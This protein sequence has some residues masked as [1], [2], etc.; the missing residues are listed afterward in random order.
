MA[1][2]GHLRVVDT[3]TGELQEYCHYCAE[4]LQHPECDELAAAKNLAVSLQR[5]IDNLLRDQHD[6]RVNGPQRPKIEELHAFWESIHPVKAK[7]SRKLKDDRHDAW[8]KLLRDHP[9]S[10]GEEEIRWAVIGACKFPYYCKKN[11]G[12]RTA[13]PPYP[14]AERYVEPDHIGQKAGRFEM[15][16]NLGFRWL[17]ENG[18]ELPEPTVPITEA[19][20]KRKAK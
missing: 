2:A 20:R 13:T 5:K 3:D 12:Q 11:V 7:R 9:G 6:E 10:G 16:A 17:K 8:A 14:G 19:K 15:L 18:E 4:G 1:K